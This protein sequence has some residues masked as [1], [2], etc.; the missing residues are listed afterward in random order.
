MSSSSPKLKGLA[1]CGFVLGLLGKVAVCCEVEL[2]LIAA[3]HAVCVRQPSLPQQT[4][5]AKG[6]TLP[7]LPQL[8]GSEKT[9]VSHPVEDPG[10]RQES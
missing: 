10:A 5:V 9:F 8:L 4:G 7:Q 6:Q 1:A 2:V 3:E